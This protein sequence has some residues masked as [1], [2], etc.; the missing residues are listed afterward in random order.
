MRCRC[1]A[2]RARRTVR[3]GRGPGR[4]PAS[5]GCPCRPA[6]PRPAGRPRRDRLAAEGGSGRLR[7]AAGGS[8]VPSARSC[9]RRT[10]GRGCCPAHRRSTAPASSGCCTHARSCTGCPAPPGARPSAAAPPSSRCAR[11]VRRR[12]PACA[13]RS[14][15]GRGRGNGAPIRARTA[16][17][18]GS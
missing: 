4:F 17:R 2:R 14:P 13:R 10:G 18:A 3:H 8:P 16:S 9:L 5:A 15:P 7:S 11:R 1:V 6:R 12:T